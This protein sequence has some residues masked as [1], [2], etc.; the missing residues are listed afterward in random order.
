MYLKVVINKRVSLSVDV[1]HIG[2]TTYIS[3][4]LLFF[5]FVLSLFVAYFATDRFKDPR[6]SFYEDCHQIRD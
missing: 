4:F 3:M 2:R 5:L 6:D 1:G